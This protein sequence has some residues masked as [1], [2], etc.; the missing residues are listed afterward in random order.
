MGHATLLTLSPRPAPGHRAP[1]LDS[2]RHRPMLG[3][4]AA[5]HRVHGVWRT[6]LRSGR[7]QLVSQAG[8]VS[9][10]HVIDAIAGALIWTGFGGF[11][12]WYYIVI[13]KVMGQ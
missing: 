3:R 8:G 11:V 9:M 12:G 4:H 2:P 10:K 13:F 5:V 7:S 1:V 6:F